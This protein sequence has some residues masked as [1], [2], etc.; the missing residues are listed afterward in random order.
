MICP[1]ANTMVKAAM[2]R[3]QPAGGR[4]WRTKAVVEATTDR[5]VAPNSAHDSPIAR[6]FD[7]ATGIAV[8]TASSAFSSASAW[9]PRK[10]C[11]TS[12]HSQDDATV[13]SPSSA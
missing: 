11:S 3:A 2:P 10:R 7:P 8:A 4:L 6:T 1:A 12:A 5:K 13:H 9:P